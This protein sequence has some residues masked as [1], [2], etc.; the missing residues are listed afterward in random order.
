MDGQNFGY[1]LIQ[2][3]HN[4]G[5]AAALAGTGF[6]LWPARLDER[7]WRRLAWLVL[8]AWGVQGISGSAFGMLSLAYYGRFPEISGIASVALSIKVFCAVTGFLLTAAY[9]YMGHAWSLPRQ[10]LAWGLLFALA[11]TALTAAAFLR[12]F[13]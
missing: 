7:S 3:L 9:L 8:T 13:S 10:R 1:A 5:A 2:I 12:W 11:A 6:S 4:F